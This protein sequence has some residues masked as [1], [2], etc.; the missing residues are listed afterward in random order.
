M[1]HVWL[2]LIVIF[3]L[4]VKRSDGQQTDD[5]KQLQQ[6]EA[7]AEREDEMN[8]DL[9][10]LLL[11]QEELKSSK[12]NINS[13][14]VRELFISGLLTEA[15]LH[16]LAMHREM[17]GDIISK[18]ELQA[19]ENWNIETIRKVLSFIS[20]EKKGLN[21]AFN[22][23][24]FSGSS[25][26]LL[27][28]YSNTIERSDGYRLDTITGER[29]YRGPGYAL[30]VRY[31]YNLNDRIR[32]SFLAEKD[33]GE[34]VQIKG[35]KLLDFNSLNISFKDLSKWC[36]QL[37]IGDYGVNVGQG[38]IQWQGFGYAKGAAVMDIFKHGP[39]LRGYGS[40]GESKYYRGI[41]T[42]IQRRKI[43]ATLFVSMKKVDA[44]IK[45]DSISAFIT[46]GLHR[47]NAERSDLHSASLMSY[48]VNLA[49]K[50]KRLNIG[51]TALWHRFSHPLSHKTELYNQHTIDGKN[52]MNA[53]MNYTYTRKNIHLFGEIAFDKRSSIAQLHG[54]ILSM[55]KNIDISF[56][57]RMIS[58][59][60]QSLNARAFTENTSVNNEIGIYSSVS[61]KTG[62][63]RFGLY[64]DQFWFPWLK[65]RV[66]APSRGFD[67]MIA[68]QWDLT[69]SISISARYKMETKDQ[70]SS[71]EQEN[72]HV[73][74]SNTRSSTRLQ[75]AYEPVREL[76]FRMRME[77]VWNSIGGKDSRG[78]LGYVE[79]IIKKQLIPV[80]LTMRLQLFDA[81]D[82]DARVYSIERGVQ[83]AFSVPFYSNQGWR[84]F[85]VMQH[86]PTVRFI[87][88]FQ[89]HHRLHF[90]VKWAQSIFPTETTT[91]AAT[92]QV[93]GN[94][95][96]EII[97]QMIMKSGR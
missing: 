26:T 77:S 88:K 8:V 53:S 94:K 82:F 18:Y 89:K 16:S 90:S 47:T 55:H 10:E 24:F 22:K 1:K 93:T 86:S 54:V 19:I 87:R 52:W 65:Y 80:D 36:K 3:V 66:D 85:I 21:V 60:F 42:T 13:D 97:M 34:P 37:I 17:Y 15:Q 48:G 61:I 56:V 79:A 29:P 91:G 23:K 75:V 76:K 6:V 69:R 83:Y 46:N 28:R 27:V 31:R 92:T 71:N 45:N 7:S 81:E 63:C 72:M 40:A 73:L 68:A 14:A 30:L 25:A 32:L 64:A 78:F 51:A 11:D 96:S 4:V 74:I 95:R 57:G 9:E 20:F 39:V 59:Q 70:N 49:K 35:A 38:L 50:F 5:E 58:P 44:N 41:A 12:V 67:Y 62:R 84:Y 43:A 33:A 2:I